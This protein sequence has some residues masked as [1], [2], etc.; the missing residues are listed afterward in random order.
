MNNYTD[1]LKFLR[2]VNNLKQKE[3]I[4]GKET[5]NSLY[6]RLET[7]KLKIKIEHIEQVC[8]HLDIAPSEFMAFAEIDTEFLQYK[9]KLNKAIN[10]HTDIIIKENVLEDYNRLNNQDIKKLT[11]KDLAFLFTYKNNLYKLWYEVEKINSDD[12]KVIV[13]RLSNKQFYS[14]YDYILALNTINYMN[15][16][17]ADNIIKLMTPL[18]YKD[19]RSIQ[20]KKYANVLLTNIISFKIYQ[21]DYEKA[22]EYV[23][24]AEDQDPTFQSY[25]FRFDIQYHK[26]LALYLQKKDTKYIDI[27]R[28]LISSI[29]EIQDIQTAKIFKQELNHLVDNP[30]YYK[31][32]T[33][34]DI[35][36]IKEQN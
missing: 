16:H 29:E 8:D 23:K 19:Q 12:I 25:Y 27:A 17:Q 33:D 3:M 22:L 1:T 31:N 13:N 28:N 26:N 20:T 2:N 10:R 9:E 21:M 5:D 7:G 11:M 36:Q 18:Q 32:N 6:S 14:M 30:A 35:V 4:I 15:N 34:Y 24:L